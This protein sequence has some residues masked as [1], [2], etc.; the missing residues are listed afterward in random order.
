MKKTYLTPATTTFEL[1]TDD[2]IAQFIISSHSVGEDDGLAKP[3]LFDE[4]DN[5]TAASPSASA[6]QSWED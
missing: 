6:Y 3:S 4:N 1:I 2:N 5:P